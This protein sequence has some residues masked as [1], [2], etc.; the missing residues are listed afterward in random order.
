MPLA[1]KFLPKDRASLLH[2]LT[3]P[4]PH[5]PALLARS[6][7]T[8]AAS[9]YNLMM[10]RAVVLM[11]LGSPDSTSVPDVKRYLNEFLMDERVID[12][13]W[14]VRSLLVKGIIVPFRAPKS[15]AAYKSIWTDNG[16][17]LLV[18]SKQQEIALQ[19]EVAEPVVIAM[20][21][22]TPSPR[23]AYD[24]LLQNNPVWKK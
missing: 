14:I 17:P 2:G 18:I 23:Q 19:K 12:K 15:A 13:P 21:Y 3:I 10:K 4:P 22:G 6:R 24:R 1:I 20:R 8:F 7:F 11:N 9:F 16:S 5:L